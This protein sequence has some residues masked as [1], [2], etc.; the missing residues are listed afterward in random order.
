[1]CS[2]LPQFWYQPYYWSCETVINPGQLHDVTASWKQ[3]DVTSPP[4]FLLT[5]ALL[6][7]DPS[8]PFIFFANIFH[9]T[10]SQLLTKAASTPS[11]SI[12]FLFKMTLYLNIT[13]VFPLPR[14]ENVDYDLDYYYDLDE[15]ST[16][17]M[18]GEFYSL[19]SSLCSLFWLDY[20]FYSSG[21]C[22]FCP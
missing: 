9:S 1:M 12:L 20:S 21:S 14:L 11:S 5:P 7:S 17:S 15:Y 3:D 10:N 16:S 2:C 18:P 8:V 19:F 13:A 4:S 6:H 22:F